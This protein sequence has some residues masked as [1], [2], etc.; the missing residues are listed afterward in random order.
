MRAWARQVRM[1]D[2]APYENVLRR[3]N[4]GHGEHLSRT[5]VS[6]IHWND[7]IMPVWTREGHPSFSPSSAHFLVR[8]RIRTPVV[9]L[10]LPPL[11]SGTSGMM[12]G[13]TLK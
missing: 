13:V 5:I 4:H 2:R 8:R 1:I 9:D 7:G 3:D 12:T 10:G 11:L 6:V